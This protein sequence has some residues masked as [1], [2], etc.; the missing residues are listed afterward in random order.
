MHV[1]YM[2]LEDYVCVYASDIRYFCGIF[3]H[4]LMQYVM[5][6]EVIV[7]LVVMPCGQIGRFQT[8]WHGSCI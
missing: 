8:V 3:V 4:I 7:I 5:L 2:A 6:I 1:K